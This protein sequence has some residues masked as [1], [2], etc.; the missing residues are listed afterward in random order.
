[1][2]MTVVTAVVEEGAAAQTVVSEREDTAGE[3]WV[4]RLQRKAVRLA[5]STLALLVG[6]VVDVDLGVVLL[7]RRGRGEEV[8]TIGESY[9]L[10]QLQIGHASTLPKWTGQQLSLRNSINILQH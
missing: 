7:R 10:V 2:V 6:R 5:T 3:T 8:R 4:M 1:M 9:H